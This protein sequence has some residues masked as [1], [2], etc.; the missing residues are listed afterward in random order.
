MVGTAGTGPHTTA[1]LRSSSR[2]PLPLLGSAFEVV[3]RHQPG[4]RS[5]SVRTPHGNEHREGKANAQLESNLWLD[6]LLEVW[7]LALG[8]LVPLLV[9]EV[10]AHFFE[11]LCAHL[12]EADDAGRRLEEVGAERV[13]EEVG[14]EGGRAREDKA[15][16][17]AHAR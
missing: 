8:G 16:A 3:A 17:C 5:P 7:D 9:H 11:D 1:F 12:W 2:L 15:V 4:C 13:G 14:P 6:A 10:L